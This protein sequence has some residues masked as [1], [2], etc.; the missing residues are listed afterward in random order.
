M[1]SERFSDAGNAIWFAKVFGDNVRFVREHGR[2]IVN[3]GTHWRVDVDGEVERLAKQA[4]ASIFMDLANPELT[5]SPELREARSKHALKSEQAPRLLAAISLLKS[6]PGI[7]ISAARLDTDAHLLGVRGGV[8]DLRTGA[9]RQPRGDEYV[10]RQA[11]AEFREGA[12]CPTWLRFLDRIMADD[13]EMIAFLQRAVGYSLTGDTR[14]QAVFICHGG[15][16]NGKS[17]FLRT[18]RELLGAYGADANADT[19]LERRD[20]VASNDLARLA[21]ARLVAVSEIDEGKRLAE[22]LVKAATGGEAISAR[23]LY[24][25]Y[26]SFVPTFKLWLAVNHKPSIR[27]DDNGIWRRI[28]LVPF[29]VTI[30]PD[31]QDKELLTKLRLELPG[32]LNWALDGCAAW[33][34]DGLAPPIEVTRA[35]A[36]YR[37]E[38]DAIGEWIAERCTV[39]GIS[40]VQAKTLYD[41]YRAFTEARGGM[42]LSMRRWAQ[43]L[44]DRGFQKDEGRVVH[45]RGIALCALRDH[46]DQFPGTSSYTHTCSDL[47][48][49]GREGRNGRSGYLAAREGE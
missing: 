28:R 39:G 26:F 25:E 19:F 22:S 43:R 37:A 10:C 27:G 3:A 4:I 16:S 8:I 30:A 32:I 49:K 41:D 33:R 47:P 46:C 12:R 15:G 44:A 11:H 29:R 17:V 48:E 23:F 9:L 14:E 24:A 18:I 13:G 5:S 1:F 45:Y 31:E 34:R 6:E 21:G 38:S 36:A 42:A 35:T 20:G 40:Q 7:T 2:W